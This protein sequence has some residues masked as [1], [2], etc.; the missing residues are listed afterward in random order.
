MLVKFE[1]LINVFS[2]PRHTSTVVFLQIELQH[3]QRDHAR[4]KRTQESSQYERASHA[5]RI[6]LDH[7]RAKLNL[8]VQES[9]RRLER[10]LTA[11]VELPDFA[12]RNRKTPDPMLTKQTIA[13]YTAELRE[14]FSDLELHKRILMEKATAQTDL[15]PPAPVNGDS[16]TPVEPQ[17][18]ARQLVE[19]GKWSWNDIKNATKELESRVLAT[20]EHLYADVYTTI[21]DL[22]DQALDLED[23]HRTKDP[24][25]K[26]GNQSE[27]LSS[28]T[29]TIGDNL[30]A[31][32]IRAAELI[33]KI[34]ELEQE[35]DQLENEK[36]AMDKL[37]TEVCPSGVC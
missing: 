13:A 16:T 20:A 11:L 34:H 2:S 29:N 21:A 6:I 22:K 27:V 8:R 25:T 17:L 12:S 18:T 30:S 26:K 28:T 31:Q 37:C 36:R 7:H 19:R 5:T 10:A 23:P 35:R 24:P 15:P 4:W 14:W 1:N 3:A 9:K 32:A 33:S